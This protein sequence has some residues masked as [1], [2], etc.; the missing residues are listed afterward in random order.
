MVAIAAIL[1]W[2]IHPLIV[3]TIYLIFALFD[4]M[5]LSEALLKIP[6]GAWFTLVVALCIATIM[7]TWRYG[8]GKQWVAYSGR[9]GLNEVV[10]VSPGEPLRLTSTFGG[11]ELSKIKGVRYR[12][13]SRS[14][15]QLTL[16]WL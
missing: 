14:D 2:R 15:L 6:D 10:A 8:K 3:F 11:R 1:V 16:Y 9:V 13:C 12:F 4:G 5:Y 7:G